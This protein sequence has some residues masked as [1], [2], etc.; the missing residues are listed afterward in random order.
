MERR[1][2]CRSRCAARFSPTRPFPFPI[3]RISPSPTAR[4]RKEPSP[5]SNGTRVSRPR[6]RPG[7]HQRKDL[8]LDAA[9]GARTE[10]TDI[11]R[12]STPTDVRAEMEYRDP[13]G[14]T[15][16]VSNSTTIW[17]A[18]WLA[19]I[20]A[21]DWIS[22]PGHVRVSRRGGRRR[23]ASRSPTLRSASKFSPARRSRYRKRLIGG[24]Y[25][26]DNTIETRRAG[27]LCSGS[28]RQSRTAAVRREDLDSPARL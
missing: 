5:A 12:S 3:S 27:E 13:N 14:E 4:S 19:G 18:K 24:F 7:V 10:I 1:A 23:A 17:P 16:T 28:D 21:D 22:S 9:G 2:D 15:Q 6:S 20:R 11:A 25:A 26:Y 8:T